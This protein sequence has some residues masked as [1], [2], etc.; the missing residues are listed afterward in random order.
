MPN[1]VATIPILEMIEG[2]AKPAQMAVKTKGIPE[3]ITTALKT[4]SFSLRYSNCTAARFSG[5]ITS[6]MSDIAHVG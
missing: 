6:A 4:L 3:N 1:N 5:H 2:I